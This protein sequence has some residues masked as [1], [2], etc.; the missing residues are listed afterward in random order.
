MVY[1]H[2]CVVPAHSSSM[3]AGRLD[4]FQVFTLGQHMAVVAGLAIDMALGSRR[5]V[6][7]GPQTVADRGH[8]F[9]HIQLCRH[10]GRAATDAGFSFCHW[11]LL[12]G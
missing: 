9:A 7:S 3:S 1:H 4:E 2:D 10:F 12:Y 11:I 5:D 6:Q 8:C